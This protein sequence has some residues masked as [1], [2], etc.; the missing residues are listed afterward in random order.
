VI[1]L[2]VQMDPI[3]GINIEGD[4]TFALMLE[5]QKRGHGI[6]VFQPEDVA[7]RNG[8]VLA[9]ARAVQVQDRKG[10]HFSVTHEGMIA[11]SGQDIVLIR[12]DPPFDMAYVANT[13]LL[14]LLEPRV[15]MF[16]PPRAIRNFSE[17][18]RALELHRFMPDTYIGRRLEDIRGFSAAFD[19]VVVKP[20]FLGGGTS[21]I[22]SS[23]KSEDFISSVEFVLRESGKEPIIVQ[24]YIPEI[25]QGDKR[26]LVLDGKVA[27]VLRR[28]PAAGDFRA[29]IHV[30]G[31]P[32]LDRLTGQEE[33][34]CDEVIKLL[35]AEGII[36]AGID[37][38]FGH[39]NEVNVTSP[40][41]I[42]EYARVSGTDL[43]VQ[44]MDSLER[45]VRA[46][47]DTP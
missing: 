3:E 33:R 4:T 7:F 16:N 41:L 27:G 30:G 36:F 11:L 37:L 29:N 42:R 34:I 1:S 26:V 8:D 15:V 5:A 14:E 40:T 39:L 35:R 18:L 6:R 17:K 43:A 13:F 10:A 24:R 9:H 25:M 28:V 19:E 23:P 22:K 20:I 12:Q 46:R 38:I 31:S 44:I 2:G 47:A 21:V 45:R 32:Q